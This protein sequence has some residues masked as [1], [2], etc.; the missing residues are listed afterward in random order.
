MT[1]RHARHSSASLAIWLGEVRRGWVGASRFLMPV[2]SS[3][4]TAF[5]SACATVKVVQEQAAIVRETCRATLA[6]C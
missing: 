1:W 5:H 6:C 4:F 3:A 2:M